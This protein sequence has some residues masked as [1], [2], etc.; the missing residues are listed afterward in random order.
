ML[1]DDVHAKDL[2]YPYARGLELLI[3]LHSNA[4]H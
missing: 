2:F 1:K 4:N 3:S